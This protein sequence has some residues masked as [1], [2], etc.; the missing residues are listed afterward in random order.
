MKKRL[1]AI[2][3]LLTACDNPA[4]PPQVDATERAPNPVFETQ[5]QAVQKARAVERQAM[6]AAEEQRKLVEQAEQQ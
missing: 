6:D 4:P 5:I 1:I 2:T 3:L